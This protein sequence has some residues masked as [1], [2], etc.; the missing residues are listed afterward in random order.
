V[1]YEEKEER[2]MKL[3]EFVGTVKEG[4]SFLGVELE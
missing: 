1:G 2:E 4:F 3:R